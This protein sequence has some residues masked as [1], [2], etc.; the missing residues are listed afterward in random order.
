MSNGRPAE[1]LGFGV[2]DPISGVWSIVKRRYRLVSCLRMSL[3]TSIAVIVVVLVVVRIR[4]D[5][6][7]TPKTGT[8]GRNLNYF[9]GGL[10]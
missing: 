4:T 3:I 1:K 8:E 2:W 10:S 9:E 7:R 6:S 5:Y